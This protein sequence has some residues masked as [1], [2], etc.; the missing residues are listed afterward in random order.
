MA[1]RNSSGL[2]RR[3]SLRHTTEKGAKDGFAGRSAAQEFAL[4][5]CAGQHSAAFTGWNQESESFGQRAEPG[6]VVDQVHCDGGR[7]GNGAKFF[8]E[9]SIQRGQQRG[10]SPGG[11][12]EDDCVKAIG[13][14]V[15]FDRPT[16][17]HSS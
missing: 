7:V 13:S 10:G 11:R 8:A 16:V 15:R 9:R 2:V 12:G 3:A 4:R 1:I 5:K 6:F 17:A 14:A